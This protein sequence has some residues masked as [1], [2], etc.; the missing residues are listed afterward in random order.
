MS[1][2]HG[3]NSLRPI[4]VYHERR[5]H[6]CVP[7]RHAGRRHLPDGI[8]APVQP[9]HKPRPVCAQSH[10]R[11]CESGSRRRFEPASAESNVDCHDIHAIAAEPD[12]FRSQFTFPGVGP[13]HGSHAIAVE[14]DSRPQ[15]VMAI[16]LNEALRTSV[17]S[18]DAPNRV[19]AA[20]VCRTDAR[21]FLGDPVRDEGSSWTG[22]SPASRARASSPCPSGPRARCPCHGLPSGAD[23]GSAHGL[24]LAQAKCQVNRSSSRETRPAEDSA[25]WVVKTSELVSAAWFI[26]HRR[27]FRAASGTDHRSEVIFDHEDGSADAGWVRCGAIRAYRSVTRYTRSTGKSPTA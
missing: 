4:T 11:K 9:V 21:K 22:Q 3:I 16:R 8:H 2:V 5:E 6:A 15:V 13:Q 27:N 14:I 20:S 23:C 26:A 25:K 18:T 17:G 7:R 12:G 24:L 19:L 1:A 10:G